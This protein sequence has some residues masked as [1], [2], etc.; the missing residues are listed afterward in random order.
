MLL[1]ML[2]FL[3]VSCKTPYQL[4]PEECI[5]L[6]RA[7]VNARTVCEGAFALRVSPLAEAL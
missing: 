6:G 1:L 2:L 5:K 3:S 4:T 7:V